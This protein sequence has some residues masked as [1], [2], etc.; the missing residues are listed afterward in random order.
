MYRIYRA[1]VGFR[2][3]DCYFWSFGFRGFGMQIGFEP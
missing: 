3:Y 2:V 1:Y